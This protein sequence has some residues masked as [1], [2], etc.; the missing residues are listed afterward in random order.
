MNKTVD[1]NISGLAFTIEIDAYQKLDQY[2]KSIQL[3]FRNEEGQKEIMDDIKSRIAELFRDMMHKNEEVVNMQHVEKVIQIMGEAKDYK[4][5]AEDFFDSTTETKNT[6]YS[7]KLYRDDEN[8][9]LG[10]VC[11][12]LG[13]YFGIDKIWFR[14]AFILALIIY[15]FGVLP[16]LI[17]W[18]IVPPAKTTAEKLEMKG[19]AIN[20]GNIGNAIKEEFNAFKKK[21][22]QKNK[23]KWLN[24]VELFF[25]NIFNFIINIL[26]FAIQF[27]IKFIALIL[28]LIAF[29]ILLTIFPFLFSSSFFNLTIHNV[30]LDQNLLNSY[31]SIFFSSDL[32]YYFAVV[33]V[34]LLLIIPLIAI[35][36]NSIKII[37]KLS[38]SRKYFVAPA[39]GLWLIGVI[40]LIFSAI[41]TINE[42]SN[43]QTYVNSTT[44]SSIQGDTLVV[45]VLEKNQGLVFFDSDFLI[46]GDSMLI[47][48]TELD[49][50]KSSDE[51]IKLT[52]NKYARGNNRRI[53]GEKAKNIQPIYEVKGNQLLFSSFYSAPVVDKFRKQ[54]LKVELL[55]P[56][57]KSIYF[58][59]GSERI[60]YD[61]KNASNTYDGDMI[62]HYWTMTKSGL[63]CTDC[64]WLTTP[65]KSTDDGKENMSDDSDD[66][67]FEL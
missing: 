28:G 58:A 33:G 64:K 36:Y 48:R 14:L 30:T 27:V 16:Y 1:V 22:N 5:D 39:I 44:L 63:K 43:E 66:G 56:E 59:P 23:S 18:I 12:G 57:G 37:F 65:S 19:E 54:K 6:F 29:F 46:D 51:N 34:G 55:L 7:K 62:G 24:K 17:L 49:V 9:T 13:H 53:A 10:G 60:I 8:S 35:L 25:S 20:I 38:P 11:A 40:L 42:F 67:S 31:A 50:L 4:D 21:V 52:F 15:G 47:N 3:L 2:L 26:R 32:M 41:F 45:D 61:I